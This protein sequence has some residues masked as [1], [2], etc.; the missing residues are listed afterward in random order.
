MQPDTKNFLQHGAPV[1]RLPFALSKAAFGLLLATILLGII[2]ALST[3]QNINR[4]RTIMGEFLYQKGQTI[5]KSIEAGTRTSMMHHMSDSNPLQSLLQEN[6]L[7]SE[8]RFIR[9][10][11]DQGALIAQAGETLEET[12]QELASRALASE[13]PV[14]NLDQSLGTFTMVKI[15]QPIY[16]GLKRGGKM[17]R[18]WQRWHGRFNKPDA[19]IISLGLQTE[20]FDV[21]RRQDVRHALLMGGVLFMLGSCAFYFLNTY[22]AMRVTRSTLANME[23][24]TNNVI[25]SMPAGLITLD[26]N[27]NI[28]SCNHN[29][30]SI[31]G[32]PL[33]DMR[34]KGAMGVFGGSLSQAAL[35]REQPFESSLDYAGPDGRSLSL[36]LHGS[37]LLDSTGQPLGRVL[38]FS[39]ISHLKALEQQLERS[40]RMSALGTMAAGIAHEIR[41]PL[42]TLRGF[43]QYFGKQSEKG[44]KGRE[45]ADLMVSEVDRLN[46]NVSALLQFARQPEPHCTK[47]RLEAVIEKATALMEADI[48]GRGLTINRDGLE[49]MELWADGDLLLQVIMNLLKNSSAATPEGGTIW[50]GTGCVND[51]ILLSVT[52]NGR[53]MPAEEKE[54]MFDPFFTTKKEGTGLGLA[55]SH[56]I[57]EQHGGRFE[58]DSTPG[59]GTSVTMI[60]PLTQPT[61]EE[62]HG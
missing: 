37:P 26:A 17:S 16:P 10:T 27:D 34:G 6:S 9:I 59:K 14:Y 31:L 3:I 44:S 19:M 43:A 24:Y 61:P 7:D 58:V 8:V 46:Q 21:A 48:A 29:A 33:E 52:D 25:E 42:G 13:T 2:L 54:R 5:I 57:L 62:D 38:I 30:E 1:T 49:D 36:T 35:N 56:Q 28:L 51:E 12:D 45:Y 53:G 40:R 60:F 22:Q 39:D 41:N 20:K 50:I 47:V 55:V 11:D 4:A 18:T 23:L 32:M 15:F